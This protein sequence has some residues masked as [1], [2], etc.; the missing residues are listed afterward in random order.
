MKRKI[1]CLAAP[2]LFAVL[3][4]AF[5]VSPHSKAQGAS[6]CVRTCQQEALADAQACDGDRACLQAVRVQYV[7]CVSTCRP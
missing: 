7:A 6:P 3:A 4:V 1:A 5:F 2:L